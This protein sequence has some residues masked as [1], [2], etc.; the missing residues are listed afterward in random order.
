MLKRGIFWALLLSAQSAF[1]ANTF[2]LDSFTVWRNTTGMSIADYAS[3]SAQ[4]PLFVD[5]FGDGIAPPSAPAYPSGTAASYSTIGGFA[6]GTEQSGKLETDTS[7]GTAGT[8]ASGASRL[9]LGARLTTNTSSDITRGLRLTH[10]FAAEGVYDIAIPD[11]STEYGI[12]LSDAASGK[13]DYAELEVSTSSS[14]VTTFRMLHQDFLNGTSVVEGNKSFSAVAGATQVALLFVHD[15]VGD[16]TVTGYYSFLN[17]SGAMLGGWAVV[18]QQDLFNGEDFTQASFVASAPGPV[19]E[20][21]MMTML[22]LGLG[23]I[24]YAKYQLRTKT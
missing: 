11:V 22:L 7:T 10:G 5:N 3:W 15:T 4:T 21:Q 12:R 20:P 18:G 13:N 1:A 8:S 6:D 9:T 19:P 17:A 16:P 24:G 14:G 2:Y 23:M